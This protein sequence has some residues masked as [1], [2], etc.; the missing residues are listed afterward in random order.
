M[1]DSS[2]AVETRKGMCRR[3]TI[4]LGM[5]AAYHPQTG[6]PAE[7]T[8]QAVEQINRYWILQNETLWAGALTTSEI[9]YNSQAR[10]G[11][12]ASPFGLIYGFVPSKL[13]CRSYGSPT[14]PAANPPLQAQINLQRARE[15]LITAKAIQKKFADRKKR[16]L[17]FQVGDQ[18]RL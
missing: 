1:T 6:G 10:S 17:V 13:I 14:I 11:P 18:V 16:P 15:E 8:N 4:S 5:S 9:A 7:R 12:K 3:L 2:F